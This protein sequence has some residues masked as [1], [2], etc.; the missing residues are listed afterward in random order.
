MPTKCSRLK[1][2]N[3]VNTIGNAICE[4]ECALFSLEENLFALDRERMDS[5]DKSRE[6]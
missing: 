2:D 1:V 3:G 4:S 6:T 5:N